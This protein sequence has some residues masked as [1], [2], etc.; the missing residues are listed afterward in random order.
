MSYY[1]EDDLRRGQVGGCYNMTLFEINR[2]EREKMRYEEERRQFEEQMEEEERRLQEEERKLQEEQQQIICQAQ[3]IFEDDINRL[4]KINK[5]FHE[6]D[7]EYRND[8]SNVISSTINCRRALKNFDRSPE[9]AIAKYNEAQRRRGLPLSTLKE[10]TANVEQQIVNYERAEIEIQKR[11]IEYFKCEGLQSVKGIEDE[12]KET[13]D[14]DWEYEV[15]ESARKAYDLARKIRL[16]WQR[17]CA[18]FEIEVAGKKGEEDVEYVI[19]WLRADGYK[20][21]FR[22]CLTKYG[23]AGIVLKNEDY[24]NEEQEFDHIVVGKNGVFLIETKNH[25]GTISINSSGDWTQEKADTLKGIKNPVQQ[26]DRHSKLIK[27]IIGG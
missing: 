8:L 25:S 1:S 13:L 15:K 19:K 27:S 24:I 9:K 3:A 23:N 6:I 11:R 4:N 10:A 5:L 22:D 16:D 7:G 14:S 20:S 18:E 26:C 17:K 2:K 12:C 21:I